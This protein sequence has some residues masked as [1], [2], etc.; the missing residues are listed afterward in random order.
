M[1]GRVCT[2]RE[3]EREKTQTTYVSQL[4]SGCSPAHRPAPVSY[5]A[6]AHDWSHEVC[7]RESTRPLTHSTHMEVLVHVL[8][9][10]RQAG[11]R[12]MQTDRHT[13]RAEKC[14]EAN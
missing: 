5:V 6:P 1:G 7:A 3:R 11:R 13:E 9:P 2:E 8:Q 12:E 14:C 10:D 4:L